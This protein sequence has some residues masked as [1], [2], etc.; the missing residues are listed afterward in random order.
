MRRVLTVASL[1][2]GVTPGPTSTSGT[3][4]V[5]WYTERAVLRLAVIAEAFA[6]IRD[7]DDRRRSPARLLERLDE[8]AELLRPWPRLRRGKDCL[9]IGVR[10]GSGGVYGACGS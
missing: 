7:D 4:I 6:V 1:V 3:C 5:A 10:N 9:R 2:P 8:P